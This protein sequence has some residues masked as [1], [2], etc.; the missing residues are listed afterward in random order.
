VPGFKVHDFNAQLWQNDLKKAIISCGGIEV[1]SV[2][3]HKVGIV[4][5]FLVID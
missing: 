2:S 1:F 3:S 5:N 4:F